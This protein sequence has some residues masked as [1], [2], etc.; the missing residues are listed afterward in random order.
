VRRASSRFGRRSCGRAFCYHDTHLASACRASMDGSWRDWRAHSRGLVLVCGSVTSVGKY[1]KVIGT[2]RVF[3]G[4]RNIAA[5]IIRLVEDADQI[6]FHHLHA[7]S[8]YTQLT[9]STVSRRPAAPRRNT[10]STR[11]LRP[12]APLLPCRREAA[13][14]AWECR[15]A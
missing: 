10:R 1:V 14:W 11:S 6:I 15:V 13:V 3:Q 4:K 12:P 9:Q 7:I 2:P 5:N 8:V